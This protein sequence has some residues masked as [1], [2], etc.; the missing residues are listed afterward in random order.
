MLVPPAHLARAR[1]LREDPPIGGWV[2]DLA[3]VGIA[4]GGAAATA[5][6][7]P[8]AGA[9][10]VAGGQAIKAAVDASN[11]AAAKRRAEEDARRAAEAAAAQA[12]AQAAAIAEAA[13][14]D[15]AA[16]LETIYAGATFTPSKAVWEST[17]K[18]E[19]NA[20]KKRIWEAAMAAVDAKKREAEA[21]GRP[22]LAAELVAQA[23]ARLLPPV[24]ESEADSTFDAKALANAKE[25]AQTATN[26]LLKALIDSMGGRVQSPIWTVYQ[27]EYD[28]R[29]AASAGKLD[30]SVPRMAATGA[31]APS[32]GAATAVKVAAGG[33]GLVAVALLARSALRATR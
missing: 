18:A 11:A 19:N 27:A 8:A 17:R 3:N 31:G 6:G 21:N 33:A 28:R 24:Y 14:K 23:K 5:F 25:R 4:L 32:A 15:A 26:A 13:R 2:S 12:A 9:A 1:A 7:G 22:E 29:L 10:V 30:T 16:F 20:Q